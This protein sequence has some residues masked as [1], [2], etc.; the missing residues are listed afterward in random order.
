MASV[1]VK[2]WEWK[3]AQECLEYLLENHSSIHITTGT[4]NVL[5]SKI[6]VCSYKSISKKTLENRVYTAYFCDNYSIGIDFCDVVYINHI[7]NRS[8]PD[9]THRVMVPLP[10]I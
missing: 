7:P 8:Y 3:S 4:K 6:G 5:N 10:F 1:H 9:K 2:H